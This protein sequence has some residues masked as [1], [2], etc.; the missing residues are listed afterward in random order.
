M[1]EKKEF[2]SLLEQLKWIE[3]ENE[4]LFKRKT[5]QTERERGEKSL[6]MIANHCDISFLA[7]V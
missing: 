6:Q 4:L 1:N 5:T 2:L 7:R 3:N